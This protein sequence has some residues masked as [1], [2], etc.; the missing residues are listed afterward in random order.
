MNN[1]L[2][3]LYLISEILYLSILMRYVLFFV[4]FFLPISYF[5]INLLKHILAIYFISRTTRAFHLSIGYIKMVINS[6][7]QIVG[8]IISCVIFSIW[9]MLYHLMHFPNMFM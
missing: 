5:F 1:I 7:Y 6:S 3:I 8:E 2:L 4:G 9:S